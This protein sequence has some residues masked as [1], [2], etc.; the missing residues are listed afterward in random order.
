MNTSEWMSFLLIKWRLGRDMGLEL[1]WRQDFRSIS[2]FEKLRNSPRE[3]LSISTGQQHWCHQEHQDL[4]FRCWKQPVFANRSM[5]ISV[6]SKMGDLRGRC[7]A[8]KSLVC[9]KNFPA[10]CH[11]QI[12]P[13]LARAGVNTAWCEAWKMIFLLTCVLFRFHVNLPGCSWNC[14]EIGRWFSFQGF[15][16]HKSS[17]T[18]LSQQ[19]VGYWLL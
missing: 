14:S 19:V 17:R 10:V 18:W 2:V 11:R 7:C 5:Y 13:A 1:R 4:D 16:F 15:L 3:I 12:Q 9:F 6:L 8:S